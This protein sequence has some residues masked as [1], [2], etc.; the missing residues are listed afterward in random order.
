MPWR[1]NAT[2]SCSKR[3][4]PTIGARVA[5]AERDRP[6]T[7]S[8]AACAS[9]SNSSSHV[10]QVP[11]GVGPPAQFVSVPARLTQSLT[12]RRSR[13]TSSVVV[14][15][16][17]ASGS[18]VPFA[19]CGTGVA[20]SSSTSS[21]LSS[22]LRTS[23]VPPF[24]AAKAAMPSCSDGTTPPDFIGSFAA[25]RIRYLKPRGRSMKPF[26][27]LSELAVAVERAVVAVARPRRA[28]AVRGRDR[29]AQAGDGHD[30]GAARQQRTS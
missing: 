25:E 18:Y 10:S 23:T 28:K 17:L 1:S 22:W 11:H 21:V 13:S 9:V 2:A 26:G 5:A 16:A 8:R 14:P 4:M 30:G 3:P 27:S 7:R 15:P 20:P 6:R 12:S 19:M 24:G 29:G